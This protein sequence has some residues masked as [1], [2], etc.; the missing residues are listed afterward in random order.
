MTQDFIFTSESVTDGHPDKL[1]DQISDAIVDRF[2]E[3]DPAA[4]VVAESAVATGI[5]FIA[6]RYASSARIDV[7]EVARQ[8]IGEIG[9]HEGAFNA[10]DCTIMTSIQ[11]LH[12]HGPSRVDVAA[13]PEDE[14]D[15]LVAGHQVTVFGYACNHTDELMPAPI[16]L[17]HRLAR[18]L[19]AV[20]REGLLTYL[21]PDGQ[22]QVGLE[23][24]AGRPVRIHSLSLVASQ[25]AA[26]QPDPRQMHDELIESVVRPS[27]ADGAL[28][29][30]DKTKIYVNPEGPLVEGGPA[31]HAGLTGRK[32]GIDAYGEYARHSGAAL[33]GKDPLRIDRVAAYAAR[34]AAKN[35]VAAGLAEAC[36]VQ[37]S[38]MIG[39]P[40][41]V[42]IQV[43]TF[44]T[45]PLGDIE[46]GNRV[47]RVCD[48]RLAGIV[49][50][51]DLQQAPRQGRGGFFRPLAVY[52]Q[53]GR[54]D[55]DVPWERTDRVEAL[56]D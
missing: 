16:V 49:K 19:V 41:P 15:R 25:A 39:L 43:E 28:R 23:Y 20:R 45:A 48:F 50:T 47:E 14:L 12:D 42:S 11:E 24:R 54:T 10:D 51:F 17:A 55:L 4:R 44:G 29:L 27:F 8:V 13:L 33:S 31:V 40:R 18:R 32:T 36:E 6:T 38:Y 9:Y 34:H 21:R 46:I 53:M 52:G 7:V 1:C 5:V 35:V 22:S 30:D 3:S 56:T 37:L 2:L 26:D